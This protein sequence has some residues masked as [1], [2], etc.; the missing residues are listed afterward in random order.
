ME[1]WIILHVVKVV[2]DHMYVRVPPA[3]SWRA[4]LLCRIIKQQIDQSALSHL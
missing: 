1:S 4:H 3:N 2:N